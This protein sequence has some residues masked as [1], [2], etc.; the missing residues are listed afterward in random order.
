MRVLVVGDPHFTLNNRAE[1]DQ[2]QV[3]LLEL[4][5]EVDLV[6]ILGDILDRHSQIH[7]LVF[8]RAVA[9]L[10]AL[11]DQGST[12]VLIGNHDRVNNQD[13]LSN[14]HPFVGQER[15]SL[16]IIAQPRVMEFPLKIPSRETKS[17]V[18]VEFQGMRFLFC[19]FVAEGRWL[20]AIESIN[21]SE[22]DYV[23]AHQSFRGAKID[24]QVIE[25]RDIWE[26]DA[27]LMISGHIHERQQ[28]Q[29]NLLYI[30]TPFQQSFRESCDKSVS[31]FTLTSESWSEERVDLHIPLKRS[32]E[33]LIRQLDE[34]DFGVLLEKSRPEMI[35]LVLKG[36]EAEVKAIQKSLI[37]QRLKRERYKIKWDIE[38]ENRTIKER[39]G[40][41]YLSRLLDQLSEAARARL[42]V[43]MAK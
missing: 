15:D 40:L 16:Y 35:R 28:I 4:Q 1:T 25:T 41:N 29:P 27:P 3:D 7:L 22:I 37:Y 14:H 33:C 34:L 32:F 20:E 9:L 10:Q 39:S 23:F 31:I 36:T 13:F 26:V 5:K 21:L 19:P 43:I 11:A 38:G 24:G 30:G 17:P 42:Q 8:N 2:L 6:V 12:V 18:G